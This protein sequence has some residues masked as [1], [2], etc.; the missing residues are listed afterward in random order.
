MMRSIL[1]IIALVFAPSLASAQQA[2]ANT[3]YAGPTTGSA[4]T[5]SF[6]A[7]VGADMPLPGA[8]SLGGIESIICGSHTWVN[9][10]SSAGVPGCTQP[11]VSDLSGL[12][13]T[14]AQG[15]TG[16]GTQQGALNAIECTP[17]RAGDIGYWNG[18]NWVCFAGNNSGTQVFS[19]NSSGVPSWTGI[20]ST[21]VPAPQGRLSLTSGVA[22][23]TT[24]VT[25]ATTIFYVCAPLNQVP[26]YT[27]SAD[28]IDTITSC[29]MS[30]TLESSG[31]GVENSAN[32]FDVWWWHNSGSP[33]VCVATNGSGGGWAS[34][35]GG[36]N[37]ARGTGYSQIDLTTRAYYTNKNA[38][39]HCYNGTTDYGSISANRATF[40]G[41]FY[42]NGGAGLAE[43]S[44]QN[45][46]LSNAYNQQP[47]P[48]LRA[49]SATSWSYSTSSY[50]QAN[51]NAANQVTVLSGLS[52]VAVSL[53]ITE[54]MLNSTATY[55]SGHVGIGLDSTS[56]NSATHSG[57]I[58]ANNLGAFSTFGF[59][60]GFPGIG[61]HK[62][63][64]LE[65]GAGSDT[66]TWFGT[67]GV[68]GTYKNGLDGT[69]WN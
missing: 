38:L 2:P 63:V 11:A 40:L 61:F 53:S 44:A 43:D 31:T 57:T 42:T 19:E 26:Y 48:L 46:V 35:T 59:F 49:E 16:A 21:L 33:V 36:S 23:T 51:A 3:V 5:P 17:T 20:S 68:S 60:T 37:T 55:R 50:Q 41:S 69:V 28:A 7:L 45:R 1:F 24:D 27:G 62:L 64:W 22:I 66:Q 54:T 12:P 30:L 15:G 52:G 8:S 32:V 18:S 34:D 65:E 6:R 13:V 47:R 14:I 10:I 56:V 58:T 4:A 39:T 67:D 25:G 9:S 29:N